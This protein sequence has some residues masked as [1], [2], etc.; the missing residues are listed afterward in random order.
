MFDEFFLAK[1]KSNAFS[2]INSYKNC[3][4]ENDIKEYRIHVVMDQE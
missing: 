2:Q 1:V 3:D 4:K